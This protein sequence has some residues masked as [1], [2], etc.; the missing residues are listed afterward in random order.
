MQSLARALA[1]TE[2]PRVRAAERYGLDLEHSELLIWE[3]RLRNFTASGWEPTN[4]IRL[5]RDNENNEEFALI[6]VLV[7]DRWLAA[8][9]SKKTGEIMTFYPFTSLPKDL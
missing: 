6:A 1:R 9:F 8:F 7:E 2:H 4:G 3:E 5:I